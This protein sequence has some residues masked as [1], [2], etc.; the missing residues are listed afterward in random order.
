MVK[1]NEV[2]IKDDDVLKLPKIMFAKFLEIV[3]EFWIFKFFT[4]VYF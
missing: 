2:N 1:L 3:V 4:F